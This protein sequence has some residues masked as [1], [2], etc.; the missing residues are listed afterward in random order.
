MYVCPSVN[1]LNYFFCQALENQARA[2]KEEPPLPEEDITK[3]FRP[4]PVPTRLPAMLMATQ[5]D[6]YAEEIAKFSTQSLAKL[7][8]TKSMNTNN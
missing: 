7:Y 5:V 4:L 2:A 8:M 3:I 1:N 6:T